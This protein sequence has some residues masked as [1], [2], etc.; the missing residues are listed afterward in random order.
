ML[1]SCPATLSLSTSKKSC[2]TLLSVRTT[3]PMPRSNEG[4]LQIFVFFQYMAKVD[5]SAAQF[6]NS[7]CMCYKLTCRAGL[8][9][10]IT[11]EVQMLHKPARQ[12][13]VITGEVQV[14]HTDPQGR[15][16]L[17]YYRGNKS[18]THTDLQGR[19]G[20]CYYRGNVSVTHRPAGQDWTLLLLGKYKCYTLTCRTRLD[21]VTTG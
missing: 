2:N 4:Y 5:Y 3:G 13:S 17:C 18:V 16:G 8:D 20:H 9:C 7:I 21:S 12:D 1:V 14:L 19:A 10:V 15:A 6:L 11:G